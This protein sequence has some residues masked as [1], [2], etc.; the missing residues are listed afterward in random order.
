MVLPVGVGAV[1]GH[2]NVADVANEVVE[3]RISDICMSGCERRPRPTAH[4]GRL[5]A[6]QRRPL[7][8]RHANV[9]RGPT[10]APIGPDSD[11]RMSEYEAVTHAAPHV[12][13]SHGRHQ[14]DASE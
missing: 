13:A 12:T 9:V 8:R 6:W 5:G 4:P 1:R 11:I 2:A 10:V 14:G 7:A 3:R